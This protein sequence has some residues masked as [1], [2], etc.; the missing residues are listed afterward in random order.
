MKTF[1]GGQRVGRGT[2]W[3]PRYGGLVEIKAEGVLPGGPERVY[4][5]VSLVPLFLMVTVLGGIYV[6]LLP[7]IINV[8]G[9]YLLC[10]RIFGG[11]LLQAKRSVGFGWRPTEA[12]L[13]GMKKKDESRKP[14]TQ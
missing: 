13:S 3:N 1:G 4:R 5:R 2:Y 11:A 14:D 10:R 12:Y 9:V 7:L 6:I 8:M